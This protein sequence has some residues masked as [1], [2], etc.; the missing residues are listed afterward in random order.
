MSK[1]SWRQAAPLLGEEPVA[2]N[3]PQQ[4]GGQ[5]DGTAQSEQN[6]DARDVEFADVGVLRER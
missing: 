2:N 5:S 1:K 3:T 4:Q 6:A